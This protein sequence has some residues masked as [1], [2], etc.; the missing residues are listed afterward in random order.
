MHFPLLVLV[1]LEQDTRKSYT[2]VY[3]LV[4]YYITA[5]Q[6]QIKGIIAA[7]YVCMYVYVCVCVCVCMYVHLQRNV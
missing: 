5:M 3:V 2:N 7:V 6:Q 4:L 1:P